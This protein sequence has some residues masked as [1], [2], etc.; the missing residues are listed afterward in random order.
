MMHRLPPVAGKSANRGHLK[1]VTL[2][3]NLIVGTEIK[4]RLSAAVAQSHIR[5]RVARRRSQWP[6]AWMSGR[7]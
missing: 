1:L 3:L 7:Q 5:V 4:F 2:P 6:G